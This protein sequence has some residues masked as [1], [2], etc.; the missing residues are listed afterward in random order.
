MKHD[1]TKLNT[2][3]KLLF[4]SKELVSNVGNKIK[5]STT[6]ILFVLAKDGN[7]WIKAAVTQVIGN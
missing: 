7:R 2:S 1:V 5:I 4:E 3:K 6:D